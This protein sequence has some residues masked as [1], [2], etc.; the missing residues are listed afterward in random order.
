MA[1]DRID[2]E[3]ADEAV[4]EVMNLIKILVLFSD[5]IFKGW[6]TDLN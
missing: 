3:D 4:E 1:E 5:N 6:Q 2:P